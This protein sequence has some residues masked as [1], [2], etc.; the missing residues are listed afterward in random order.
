MAVLALI[1]LS[2]CDRGPRYEGLGFVAYNY[3]PFDIDTVS[4]TDQS[5][6]RAMTTQVSVGAGAGS[7]ACCYQLRG[8]EFTAAWRA[9]DSEVLRRDLY[10]K[11][12]NRHFFTRERLVTFPPSELPGGAGPVYLELHIY[13]DEHVDVALTRRLANARLPIVAT[14]RWLWAQHRQDLGSFRDGVELTRVIARVAQTS[15]GV[16]RIEDA[17]DMRQYMKMYFLVASDFDQDAGIQSVLNKSGRQPGEFAQAI[18]ALPT[19]RLAAIARA[20]AAP[21]NK[22]GRTQ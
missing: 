9:V 16:Y 4:L 14:A 13:P 20:G 15:W 17:E 2:A 12:V 1:L 7:V 18:E 8:T 22:N 11:D 6:N 3:T 19:E 21:G 10:D 5:G